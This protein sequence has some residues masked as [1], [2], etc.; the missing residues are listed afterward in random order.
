MATQKEN[1]DMAICMHG[2]SIGD[3]LLMEKHT[4]LRAHVEK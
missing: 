4:N 3:E 2:F 1:I